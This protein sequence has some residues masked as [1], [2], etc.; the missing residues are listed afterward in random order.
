MIESEKRRFVEEFCDSLKE[1]LLANVLHQN[2]PTNYN[3]RHIR[4]IA[5]YLVSEA[6]SPE[7]IKVMQKDGVFYEL[8]L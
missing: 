3:G 2:F 7:M 5:Q 8:P 1:R 6:E 4:A